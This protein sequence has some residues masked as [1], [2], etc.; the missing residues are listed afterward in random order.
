MKWCSTVVG[1]I[2]NQGLENLQF[3]P[4][5]LYKEYKVKIPQ[6]VANDQVA[7]ATQKKGT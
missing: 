1:S 2:P 4:T 3:Y 6:V 7:D 5:V